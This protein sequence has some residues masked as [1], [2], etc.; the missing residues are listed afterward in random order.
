M[1]TDIRPLI[2]ALAA[3]DVLS[4]DERS[5]LISAPWR[6]RGYDA[7]EEI[8][9]EGSEPKE[10]CLLLAGFA[11]RTIM[12]KD[13]RRQITA[14]HVPGDFVDLHSQ[15]LKVMDHNVVALSPVSV[16]FVSH[17][18]LQ[19]LSETHPHLS[20]LLM[21]T[22][23]IDGAIQRNWIAGLGRRSADAQ[24]AHLICEVFVRLRIVGLTKDMSFK[25]LITQLILA[26]VL[27][28]SVVHVN[29]MLQA[30]RASDLIEWVKQTVTIKD[31]DRLARFA[32]FD[33]TYLSIQ[34]RE[35]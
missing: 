18:F 21:T 11:G 33:P 26:D 1:I 31:W 12:F 28:L 35:R 9:Q 25:F 16:A 22:I 15:L 10:S 32:E 13:G 20:R 3:R 23:A 5:I 19:G 8:I 17:D 30:L 14:L 6:F 29:R 27:G 34:Q 4:D 7:E 2:L 24:L